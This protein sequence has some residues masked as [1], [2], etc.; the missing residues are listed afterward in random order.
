MYRYPD[1]TIIGGGAAGLMCACVVSQKYKDKKILI[2]DKENRVGK[3][4]LVSGNGRCNLSN[5]NAKRENYH[6]NDTSIID[7][8]FSKYNPQYVLDY[9]KS[10]GLITK[11][12]SDGRI[13]PRSKLATSVLNILRNDEHGN[14]VEEITETIVHDI[15]VVEDR[16]EVITKDDNI[17]THKLIIA[18]GGMADHAGREH[19]AK[20]NILKKLGYEISDLHPSLSPVRVKNEI[21]KS[22]NGIRAEGKVTLMK[23]DEVI[24]E[25]CGE[26]QFT[27]NALSGI[28]VF[29]LSREANM[30]K[31][32]TIRVSLLP[33]YTYDE[34]KDLIIKRQQYLNFADLQDLFTGMFHKNI[35]L[36]LL[37]EC[38]I[39]VETQ[40]NNLSEEDID[41]LTYKINHWDF[42]TATRHDYMN[43]QVTSGG[44]LVNQ[45]DFK[46]F[47]SKKH[48]NLYFIGEVL[49]IDGDC[50]GY[51][52]QFAFA[53]GLCCGEQL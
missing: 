16:F 39:S 47:E 5:I 23:N 8:L 51:N 30:T 3:K 15:K 29:N 52:L 48:K 12:E 4:I 49:D 19:K 25:E 33:E 24:K 21:I 35:G 13:Y 32:M 26:I 45:I 43:S 50:G 11:E 9:F 28:C 42:E 17:I 7:T 40:A 37:K 46:T 34:I 14:S 31:D 6:G 44:V 10:L 2:I 18:T 27:T 53:S 38:N 20:F 41:K 36:A 1:I 22:L